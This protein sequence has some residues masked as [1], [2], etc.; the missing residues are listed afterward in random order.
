MAP[1]QAI[2]IIARA[3]L[4]DGGGRVL[5]CRNLKH[6]YYYLPGGHVEC[7]EPA[8]TALAREFKEELGLDIATRAFLLA[9]ETIFERRG[10][11]THEV[12]LVF[13]VECVREGRPVTPPATLVSLEPKIAF[14]WVDLKKL[15]STDLR[16]DRIKSWLPRA[17]FSSQSTWLSE[18]PH[19]R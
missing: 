14:E 16:P 7:N 13:R 9:S 4:T 10:K 6:L 8:E 19:S 11:P 17:D 12:N 5:L 1:P 3:V 18:A 2:E 15:Q